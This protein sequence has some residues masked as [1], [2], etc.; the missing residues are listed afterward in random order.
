M[1]K[2][3]VQEVEISHSTVNLSNKFI[4]EISPFKYHPQIQIKSQMQIKTVLLINSLFVYRDIL[5]INSLTNK[6]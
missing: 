4:K 1:R 2:R 6:T 5:Q 3:N